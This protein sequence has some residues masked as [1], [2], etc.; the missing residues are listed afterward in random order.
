MST[1]NNKQKNLFSFFSKKAP[2]PSL[3]SASLSKSKSSSSSAAN[4]AS[5]TNVAV[6]ATAA[7][8]TKGG[9]SNPASSSSSSSF[10]AAHRMLLSEITV[11]MRL[12]VYWPDDDEHY[13]CTIRT[14]RL[15]RG[16][17]PGHM[18]ELHYEDGEVETINLARERFRVIRGKNK[19]KKEEEKGR[20]L[21]YDRGDGKD[22]D[23]GGVVTGGERFV[24]PTPMKSSK[25][26]AE[27][28]KTVVKDI[29]SQAS[30]L[31]LRLRASIQGG[32]L[33]LDRQRG[34]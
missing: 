26:E 13:P 22:N 5:A 7:G 16:Q 25:G 30:S 19:K 17:D 15:R 31:S 6:H 32:P 3:A 1:S 28:R 14:H 20:S 21:N 18:Y 2:L 24:S 29:N 34:W 4:P 27:T 12:A 10:S 9:S 33:P 11:G 23:K 8:K